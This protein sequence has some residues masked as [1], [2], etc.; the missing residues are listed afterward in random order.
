[1]STKDPLDTII[2]DP[3][4]VKMLRL[5]TLNQDTIY[6]VKEFI[7][8]LRKREHT[9]K[10][11]L[12]ALEKDGIIK[13]K[14]IPQ[15]RRKSEGIREM[16]GYGFNRR[17]VHQN[18]LEKII[19]ESVPTERDILAKKISR[20]PGVQCIIT[21]DIFIETPETPADVV[22]ASTQD[23]ETVLRGVIQETERT[24]GRELRCVFITVNDLMHRIQVNDKFIRDILDGGHQVHTDRMGIFNRKI[25]HIL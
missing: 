24:I 18:I 25:R 3:V 21:M 8:T 19:T 12:R 10:E 15:A 9:I 23:N 16:N 4:R 11:T 13:K 20:V 5:F 22:V 2:G 7:K 17:Y 6:T 1:M 14:K